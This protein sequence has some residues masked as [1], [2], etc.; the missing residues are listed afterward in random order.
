MLVATV[1]QLVLSFVLMSAAAFWAIKN[2]KRH[3]LNLLISEELSAILAKAQ[4]TVKNNPQTFKRPDGGGPEI[5]DSPELMSTIIT[6]LINKYGTARLSINDFMIS[7][8]QYVSVY[9][10]TATQEVILSLDPNLSLESQLV[11][12]TQTDNTTFH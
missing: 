7:D 8:D 11:G 10:D 1:S 4:E 12:F 5:M 3:N 9:V 6:V 2:H